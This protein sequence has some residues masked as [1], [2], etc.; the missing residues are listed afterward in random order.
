LTGIIWEGY[1]YG[2][3]QFSL[4]SIAFSPTSME[5][6]QPHVTLKH[7]KQTPSASSPT[8]MEARQPHVTPK[9]PKPTPSASSPTSMEARK[10]HVTLKHP[11]INSYGFLATL[12]GS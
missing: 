6:R 2:L 11:I 1:R 8:S 5:A 3:A 10:P 7:A 9:H 12:H 4:S